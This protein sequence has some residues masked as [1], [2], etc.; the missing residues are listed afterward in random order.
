MEIRDFVQILF[1]MWKE[2]FESFQS[3]KYL[4]VVLFSRK[5]TNT[6]I[7]DSEWLGIKF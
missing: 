1:S 7:S 5:I 6:N 3:N 2:K 4:W